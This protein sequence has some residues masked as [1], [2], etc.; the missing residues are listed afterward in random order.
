MTE[1]SIELPDVDYV[2]RSAELEDRLSKLEAETRT[3]IV[4][5]ELKAEA[6]RAGMVDLD[7]LKLLDLEKVELDAGG[8]IKAAGLLISTET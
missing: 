5:A 1:P 6:L 2:A 8:S 7:G 4:H 3:R